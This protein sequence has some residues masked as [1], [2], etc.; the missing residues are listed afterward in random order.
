[1]QNFA[2]LPMFALSE[3][4]PLVTYDHAAILQHVWF[5]SCLQQSPPARRLIDGFE[6]T[7]FTHA[8]LLHD[9]LW[10]SVRSISSIR[11]RLAD[12]Y[13][14]AAVYHRTLP[15]QGNPGL[16]DLWLY[17]PPA[18]VALFARPAP[19]LAQNGVQI[20][21]RFAGKRCSNWTTLDIKQYPEAPQAPRKPPWIPPPRLYKQP[22]YTANYTNTPAVRHL[23]GS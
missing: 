14:W 17:T 18:V 22:K 12:L 19:V 16:S 21:H 1:M 11:R 4:F 5:R 9:V 8:G 15:R 2:H 7:L 10:L 3:L 20:E 6:Y 13:L 23:E